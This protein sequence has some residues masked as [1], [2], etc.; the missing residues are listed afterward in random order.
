MEK[1]K[2]IWTHRISL[3]LVFFTLL[4]GLFWYGKGVSIENKRKEVVDI[5]VGSLSYRAEVSR[6]TATRARGLSGRESLCQSCAM[7]FVFPTPGRQSFW[8]KDMQFPLDILWIS[9]GVIVYKESDVSPTSKEILSP[10]VISDMVLEINPNPRIKAG[11]RV[12]KQD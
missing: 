8:M 12:E 3:G 10:E 9:D 4:A 1:S 11:D 7:L 5:T 6:D 2:T